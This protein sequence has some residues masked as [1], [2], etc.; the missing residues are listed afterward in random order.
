M[1]R[2]IGWMRTAIYWLIPPEIRIKLALYQLEH[3]GTKLDVEIEPPVFMP[4]KYV[5]TVRQDEIDREIK[6]AP[7]RSRG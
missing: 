5:Y 3:Y 1:I 2:G 6:K 7:S 4:V